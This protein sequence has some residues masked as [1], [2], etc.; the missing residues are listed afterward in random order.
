MSVLDVLKQ[1][2]DRLLD[3]ISRLEKEVQELKSENQKL[4]TKDQGQYNGF[5]DLLMNR[6]QTPEGLEFDGR[7]FPN[8]FRT[9][10]IKTIE[11][12][13]AGNRERDEQGY[14]IPY[15]PHSGRVHMWLDKEA[16]CPNL[17][18]LE[19]NRAYVDKRSLWVNALLVEL[20]K[21]M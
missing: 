5:R 4:E 17:P 16:G 21:M 14:L 7:D 13:E 2:E 3:K 10:V 8:D 6:V 12:R 11:W 19:E 15:R 9:L 18:T 1:H 20:K